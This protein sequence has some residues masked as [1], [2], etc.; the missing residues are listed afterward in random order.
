[1]DT[2]G[3]IAHSQAQTDAIVAR[4]KQHPAEAY[5]RFWA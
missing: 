3:T 1:V 2:N 4:L 5:Q